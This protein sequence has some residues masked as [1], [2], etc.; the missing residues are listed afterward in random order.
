MSGHASS[1]FNWAKQLVQVVSTNILTVM[2]SINLTKYYVA[3]GN[4]GTPVEG[5]LADN[6]AATKAVNGDFL[7]MVFAM[8]VCFVL[9]FFI[10]IEKEK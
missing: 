5:T 4:T 2:L 10:K 1:M 7:F 9:T 8:A 6:I 3:A